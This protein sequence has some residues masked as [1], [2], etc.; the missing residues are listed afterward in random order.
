[1]TNTDNETMDN[2]NSSS[3]TAIGLNS[4]LWLRN[5]QGRAF[6]GLSIEQFDLDNDALTLRGWLV[7]MLDRIELRLDGK[8]LAATLSRT[9]RPDVASALEI[10]ESPIG[11]GFQITTHSPIQISSDSK[12]SIAWAAGTESGEIIVEHGQSA[13]SAKD[14]TQYHLDKVEGPCLHGWV[15]I[16]AEP[17]RHIAILCEE[18]LIDCEVLR[19]SR[20]DV[21]AALGIDIV[22]VGFQLMIPGYL[23][24]HLAA[25]ENS[26]IQL[27]ADGTTLGT[28]SVTRK[29][30]VRWIEELSSLPDDSIRQYLALH[31]LEHVYYGELSNM[32]DLGALRFLQD[33]AT[34]MHLPDYLP[35]DGQASESLH[36]VE[37]LTQLLS[38]K[39]LKV[40]NGRLSVADSANTVYSVMIDVM[41][42]LSLEGEVKERYLGTLIPI[43][44]GNEQFPRLRELIDFGPWHKFE[45][46]EH[47]AGISIAVAVLVVDRNVSLATK[48]LLKLSTHLDKGWINFECLHF[49]VKELGRQFRLGQVE[50]SQLERFAHA[51]VTL[52]DAFHGEWFS[53]LHDQE[54]IQA[55]IALLDMFD[56]YTDAVRRDLIKGLLR[57]YGLVP[58]FWQ[59]LG[60]VYPDFYHAELRRGYGY[61]LQI[62]H[63]LNDEALP[64]EL[65]RLLQ[66]I[67]YF[68][69]LGNTEVIML[70]RE[71]IMKSLTQ[72]SELSPVGRILIQM[73][74][75]N[76]AEGVRLAAF[77]SEGLKP[78][79][80]DFSETS[81]HLLQTL[82]KMTPRSKSPY[83]QTQ[84]EAGALV[85]QALRAF[86]GND[87]KML[88]VALQGIRRYAA[89]LNSKHSQFLS[90]DLQ[91]FSYELGT[92]AGLAKDNELHAIAERMRKIIGET[93]PAEILPAPMQAAIAKLYRLRMNPLIRALL[94]DIRQLIQH[95]FSY[96]YE[97]LFFPPPNDALAAS[98]TGYANDT[99]VV[100]YSCR[101]YLD[102]RIAE[103]R[104]TWVQDLIA[105]QIPYLILVGDGDN[106]IHGDVLA[107]NISDKYEDLPKKTL[108]LFN[109]LL[110][111]TGF[112]YVYKIDDDCYLDVGRFFDTLSYRKH[113]Y[114]GR[115]IKRT[116]GSMDRAWHQ[117]K[118][119]TLHAQKVLDKS[120]EPSIYADGGGGY[121]LSR[122]AMLKLSLMVQTEAGQR[123]LSVSLMEDKLIGDLL[124]RC[125]ITPSDEDYESYQR[126]RTFGAALPVGMWDNLFFPCPQTPTVMTHLDTERT[127]SEVHQQRLISELWPKK[128]WPTTT[129]PLIN[130]LWTQEKMIGTNQLEL[131]SSPKQLKQLLA[132]SFAVVTVVRNELLMLPHFLEHYRRLGVKCF[133]MADNLSDD[134]TREY[135]LQQSD[136]GLFSVDTEYKK[137]HYGVAWQQALL[138]N[139][140]LNKWVLLAD[141]DELLIYPDCEHLPLVEFIRATADLEGADCIRTD[142]IDMYPYGDLAEADLREHPPLSVAQWFDAIPFTEWRLGNGHFSN[143]PSLLSSLRHRIT[144]LAEPHSFT[145]QKYGLLRY[146]PW[147]RLSQGI[148][149]ISGVKVASQHAWFAHIKYHA[150]FKEKVESEIR[151]GQHFDNAREYRRYAE[152]LAESK[153]GFG[154]ATLSSCYQGSA[155]FVALTNTRKQ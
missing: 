55:V 155:S 70:I 51:M 145:A 79:L 76:A 119:H 108:S 22:E 87:F 52:L 137:S 124:S 74:L 123:L 101:K 88:A 40:L 115:I 36:S 139:F 86:A 120:P 23:W 49:A 83:Y 100:I 140:C 63:L 118:S 65:D 98:S 12:L 14:Q 126:R 27:V 125:E 2:E 48:A 19:K 150:G 85:Q 141:A 131:L 130:Q 89:S 20:K 151:R 64:N 144:P 96:H 45:Q 72:Q 3:E 105:R 95:K 121:A 56:A 29:S 122:Y 37:S 7:G 128:I 114:Y 135:L 6:M 116:I 106:Q 24:E 110:L 146:K 15:V 50:A 94:A 54:L 25:D 41:Q 153:G 4:P 39:A 17:A 84:S 142:M 31:A 75:K 26:V 109:W 149:D 107:L 42:E 34:S 35:K 69:A 9:R 81:D 103:I 93:D 148:H 60:S 102:T 32:L 10:K 143:A 57:H 18:Q 127:M 61:W 138:G 111:N 59:L 33:F 13:N 104:K 47:A 38:W 82:H 5:Q 77:P 154:E 90:V 16:G 44:C 28:V 92:Q 112:Q 73:L 8:K 67:S 71:I 97:F 117:E 62:S 58:S 21:A 11:F 152:I 91:V 78:V 133:L 30:V 46:I 132:E 113:H 99:L 129:A 80:S 43:L 147:I 1:M 53:R 66:P 136:V 134:G 68:E